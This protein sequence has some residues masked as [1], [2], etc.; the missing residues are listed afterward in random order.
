MM[1][2]AVTAPET[3]VRIV[4]FVG[5]IVYFIGI[6]RLGIS[7]TFYSTPSEYTVN[8]LLFRVVRRVMYL[9]TALDHLETRSECI[10]QAVRTVAHYVQPATPGRPFRAECR[11]HHEPGR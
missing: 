10:Q 3:V 2:S 9:I 6:T 4:P 8:E 11:D 1:S 7:V 5:S